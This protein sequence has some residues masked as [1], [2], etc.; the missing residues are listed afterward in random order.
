MTKIGRRTAAVLGA[1]T[2]AMTMALAVSS[3]ADMPNYGAAP[4]AAADA[5]QDVKECEQKDRAYVAF[6]ACSRLLR[7][8]DATPEDKLR[9]TE[10]RAHAAL[11]LF[12]F[13]DA[14]E[15]FTAVL[16][17]EPDNEDAR[18]AAPRR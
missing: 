2:I 3:Q 18:V 7:A 6:L 9:I 8:P 12:Y 10:R 17:A 1:M 15:D 14:A 13:S 5:S 11:V 16:A 4:Q